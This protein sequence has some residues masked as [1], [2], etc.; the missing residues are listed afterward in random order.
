MV[1]SV[2]EGLVP[3][4]CRKRCIKQEFTSADSPQFSGVAEH[5]IGLIESTGHAARIQ[6]SVITLG[7]SYRRPNSCGPR[8]LTGRVMLIAQRLQKSQA[9]TQ[10]MKRDMRNHRRSSILPYLKPGYYR[11]RKETNR[12][13]KRKNAFTSALRA[14]TLEAP[15]AC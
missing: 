4:L 9:T 8:R 13:R 14:T 3:C 12:R 2:V 10:Q 1:R 7:R 11:F 6:A 15:I 5:A